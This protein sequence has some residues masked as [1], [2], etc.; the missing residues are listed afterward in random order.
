MWNFLQNPFKKKDAVRVRKSASSFAKASASA[1]GRRQGYGRQEAT[2]DKTAEKKVAEVAHSAKKP[3]IRTNLE[4][5]FGIILT[6]HV[7]EKTARAGTHD[8]YAFV[9]SRNANKVEI[10]KAFW[11]MYGVKPER[12]Q[13]ANI[14]PRATYFRRMPGA[15]AAWK[16][17]YIR[18]PKGSNIAVYEGV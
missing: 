10:A 12:V 2:A 16:K 11:K 14:R 17:A 8:T 3:S 5:G 6:P 18:V 15:Q 9:V 13:I 1:I 4:A 7:S